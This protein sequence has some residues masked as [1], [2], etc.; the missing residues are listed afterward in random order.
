[1]S[2]SFMVVLALLR[3][4]PSALNCSLL[5]TCIMLDNCCG[6]NLNF[7]VLRWWVRFVLSW[8]RCYVLWTCVVH[9]RHCSVL[10]SAVMVPF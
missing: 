9:V 6:L 4:V 3:V 10:V 5:L 2:T 8:L 1:M 7:V